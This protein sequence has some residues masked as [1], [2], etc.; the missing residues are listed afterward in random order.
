MRRS[1]VRA[2][3]EEFRKHGN[4]RGPWYEGQASL[5]KI[6]QGSGFRI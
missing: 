4:L 3:G 5:L 2:L 6:M 1:I